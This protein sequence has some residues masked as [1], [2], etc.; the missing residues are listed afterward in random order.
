MLDA[1]MLDVSSSSYVLLSH[2]NEQDSRRGT[3]SYQMRVHAMN[4]RSN[5]DC[6]HYGLCRRITTFGECRKPT[7]LSLAQSI[8]AL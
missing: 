7:K 4:R 6:M 8:D 2:A 1:W 5:I 3:S